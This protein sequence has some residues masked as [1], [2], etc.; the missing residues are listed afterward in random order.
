MPV[1]RVD[2]GRKA[3]SM[4]VRDDECIFCTIAAG[5]LGTPFRYESEHV[6]AFDDVAPQA[7]THILVIP[8]THVPDFGALGGEPAHLFAELVRAVNKVVTDGGL[9]ETGFRVL[10]NV[11]KDAGQT[12]NHLHLH[13]LG[14]GKLA[15]M[16]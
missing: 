4:T 11:G 6:V 15:P 2:P 9:S 3:H 12:V 14:G 7:P 10:V 5:E 13:V 8:R 1:A 16:G